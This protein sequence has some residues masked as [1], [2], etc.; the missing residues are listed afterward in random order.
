VFFDEPELW[1][2]RGGGEEELVLDLM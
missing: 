2:R 1:F